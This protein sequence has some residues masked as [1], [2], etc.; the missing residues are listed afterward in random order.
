MENGS[1]LVSIMAT[2]SAAAASIRAVKS[3]EK[4]MDGV[5]LAPNDACKLDLVGD[6]E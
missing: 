4:S 1:E 2:Y 3:T 5:A 6:E